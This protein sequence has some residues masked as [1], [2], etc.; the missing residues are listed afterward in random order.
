MLMRRRQKIY[1]DFK[2]GT[3]TGRFPSDCAASTAVKGLMSQV[4]AGQEVESEVGLKKKKKK[5]IQPRFRT[6]DAP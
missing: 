1:N 5:A 3:F 6:R 4:R 2:F